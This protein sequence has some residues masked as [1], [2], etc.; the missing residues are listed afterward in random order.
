MFKAER[1]GD[2]DGKEY[3]RC[4]RCGKFFVRGKDYTKH[5]HRAHIQRKIGKRYI[6]IRIRK[7]MEKSSK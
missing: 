1:I 5:I 6:K 7:K 4:P 2:K 3:L